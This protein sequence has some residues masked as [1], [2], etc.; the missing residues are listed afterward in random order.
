MPLPIY[1]PHKQHDVNAAMKFMILF[2]VQLVRES[3]VKED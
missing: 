3:E 2:L 1:L